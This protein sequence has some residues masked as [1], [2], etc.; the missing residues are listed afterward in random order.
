MLLGPHVVFT[1]GD[2]RSIRLGRGTV[3]N[4]ELV[5]LVERSGG[6]CRAEKLKRRNHSSFGTLSTQSAS[7]GALERIHHLRVFHQHS[8]YQGQYHRIGLWSLLRE[9][10]KSNNSGTPW[11]RSPSKATSSTFGPHFRCARRRRSEGRCPSIG[12]P[13]GVDCSVRTVASAPG[14]QR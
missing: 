11:N 10:V 14:F 5:A 7:R 1:G 12:D 13:D 4:F 8:L 6:I 9:I 2:D 3:G